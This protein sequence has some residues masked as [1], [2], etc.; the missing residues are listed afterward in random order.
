MGIAEERACDHRDERSMANE[1]SMTQS[2]HMAS[3]T[4]HV[5][6]LGCKVNR[7]E[8]D[9]IAASMIS[10]GAVPVDESEADLIVVN[11]CTVTGEADK[12][13]RKAV[14]H[15]LSCNDRARV[16]V[17]GC[18]AA[19]EPRV[20]E[21]MDA[22]VQVVQRIDLPGM[23]KTSGKQS[24]MRYGGGFRTRLNLKVQ[25]GCDHACTYCIVHVARGKAT[26]APF[27]HV[28][29]EA[30]AYLSRGVKEIV[31]TGIDLS[32]YRDGG[33]TLSDL[34][35]A[36]VEE[37]DKACANSELP[38][39]IRV[40]STEPQTLDARFVDLLA[41]SDGR[42]C[43]HLHLPLQSGSSKVLAEMARPYTAERYAELV[44]YLRERIPAIS[45]TTDII[46]GFPGET[47]DEFEETLELAR[48]CKFSKIHVFPYSMRK[49][50]PAALRE[51]QI[52]PV[53]KAARATRLRDL[54]EILRADDFAGRKGTVELAI[55][56]DDNALTES[57]HEL[58][59]PESAR[60]GELVR[61]Q[62]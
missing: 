25:D 21:D 52:D 33:R 49:G 37:A 51:D 15:A 8:A 55:V 44:G 27:E 40:S 28:L 56:E 14:R 57:Y 36:L 24:A 32:S 34:A 3:D 7:V 17:T 26:S 43:R 4:F 58:P 54:S 1:G 20:F 35:E 10:S 61:V 12:K 42:I 2:A 62:L 46:C 53:V 48:L 47:D 29:E 50:T 5:V 11:T 31:L 59:I 45:L 60:Q 30:R 38:A 16:I 23:L 41:E 13:A 18:A 6:N 22:R 39:R 9:V 19:I